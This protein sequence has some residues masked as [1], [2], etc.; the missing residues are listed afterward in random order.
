MKKLVSAALLALT[1]AACASSGVKF[2]PGTDATLKEWKDKLSAARKSCNAIGLE[3][4][5]KDSKLVL[6]C[7]GKVVKLGLDDLRKEAE[8]AAKEVAAAQLV[9]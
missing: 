9:K 8:K 1:C 3:Q 5:K 4:N 6:Y 2:T 7:D